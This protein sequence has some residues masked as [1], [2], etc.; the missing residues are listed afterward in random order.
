MNKQTRI[1]FAAFFGFLV[2]SFIINMSVASYSTSS[3]GGAAVFNRLGNQVGVVRIDGVILNSENTVKEINT[4][5]EDPRTV[6]ILIRIE[7]PGGAVAPSQEIFN[8]IR[9][10]AEAKPTIVSMGS[11]AA[12]GG[13]YI[14]SAATKIF[15]NPSTLTGSIG[16]IMQLSRYNE[17]LDKIG[18]A[19]EVLTA[20]RL[21]DAGSPIRE[22]SDEEREYFS[23]ILADIHD[24]FIRDIALGRNMDIDY[25]REFSEGK[26]F[27][28]NQALDLG[29]IDTLGSFMDAQNYIRELLNLPQNTT[30][31]E[32]RSPS[33]ILREFLSSVS[34]LGGRFPLNRKGGFFFISEQLL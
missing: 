2:L 24:Q 21:K 14:A 1:F 12:S 10:A 31:T 33:N 7:S 17:L 3:S 5:R 28:G 19:I 13:Y 27:T 15:A 6:A 23:E 20:G 30:F 9:T 32:N 34:P 11:V 29:L 22:L 8:A 18:V 16:V 25:V 26:I 4:F